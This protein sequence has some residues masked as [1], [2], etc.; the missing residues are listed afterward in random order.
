MNLIEKD[1]EPAMASN[2]LSPTLIRQT[3]DQIIKARPSYGPMIEFY[4]EVFIAQ[5]LNKKDIIIPPIVIDADL[6]AVKQNNHMPLIDRSEFI[7]D[8]ALAF[9]LFNTLCDF[10]QTH[11]PHLSVSAGILAKALENNELNLE[12]LFSA[13]LNNHESMIQEISKI[14]EIPAQELMFIAFNAIAPGIQ[15]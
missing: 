13:I 1:K 4:R 3:A 9:R 6:L 12:E 15:I 8:H 14:L 10:A 11:A 2:V 5:E 7:I